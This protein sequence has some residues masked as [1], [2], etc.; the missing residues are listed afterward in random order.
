MPKQTVQDV[1]VRGLRVLVRVDFNVPMEDGRI[2]DDNRIRAALPTI[3]YLRKR[4]A[5]VILCSHLG[6]PNGKVDEGSRLEPIAVGLEAVLDAPVNYVTECVGIEVEAAVAAMEPGEVLLLENLRFH[7]GEEKN[8]PEF[9]QQL[10][11]LADLYVN[12]A[13]GTAHRAH[14][15]TAGVADYLPAVSGF[16]MEREITMLGSVLENPRRPL[17]AVMGGAKVSD[18]IAVL[19]TLLDSVD[20]LVIGG[21][22]AATFIKAMGHGVG[23]SLLEEERVDFARETIERCG[24]Q[25]VKLVLPPDLVV[26]DA[27]SADAA[28]LVVAAEAIPDGWRIMDV[29]PSAVWEFTEALRPCGT[30]LWNGPMGVFEWQAFSHGTRAVGQA[31]ASLENAVTIVGGGSTAEAVGELGLAEDMTHVSTG[32]GA[33]LEFFEG[34]VLP[35]V[36]ALRDKEA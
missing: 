9:A 20:V 15:S 22:M 25:G 2:S 5:R 26:A 4:D 27:F 14:A 13:F 33:S 34:K 1:D 7:P 16:L 29:G 6:R 23:D 8:D 31:V 32:G 28:T 36:A 3:N 19:E 35:G 12:D 11:R 30:V 21:G 18:K 17:A 24:K 10:A